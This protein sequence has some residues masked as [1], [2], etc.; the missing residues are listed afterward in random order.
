[1]HRSCWQVGFNTQLVDHGM[2]LQDVHKTPDRKPTD[3][4]PS[5]AMAGGL[6]SIDRAVRALKTGFINNRNPT[7]SNNQSSVLLPDWRV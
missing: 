4:Q 7:N 2:M 6:F 1:M 5:P 3:A